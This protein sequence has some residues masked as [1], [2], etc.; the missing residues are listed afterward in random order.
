MKAS[1]NKRYKNP[2]NDPN[3][4]YVCTNLTAPYYQPSLRYEWGGKL[5]PEGRSWR[6]SKERAEQ[7]EAE[8]RIKFS[9][10]G[11]PTLKRYLKDIE[12][13]V[14]TQLDSPSETNLTIIVRT[15]MKAIALEIS[16]NPACL[17]E[18]EWRDLERVFREVFEA[19]GFSTELTRSGKDGGFDLRLCTI[20]DGKE[21]VFL[22]EVKHW[23][24]SGQ[25]PGDSV[26]SALF[27]VI[28]SETTNDTK[29]LILSSS[30]FTKKVLKGRSELEHYPVRLGDEN[31]IVS[32]CK[33]YLETTEG[34]W[35]PEVEL[36]EVL[37]DGTF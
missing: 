22:V 35:I 29:G 4:P 30:G 25:K 28:A 34:L 6:Y 5:P 33:N 11:M 15:A 18:V 23:I 7:L 2:D 20:E 31:K 24:S 37:L 14:D 12:E 16:K 19:I 10:S 1:N 9:A 36:S 13:A 3:G 26:L 17:R 32:L 8:G 27:D 21:K